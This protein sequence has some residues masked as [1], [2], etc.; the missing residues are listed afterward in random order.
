VGKGAEMTVKDFSTFCPKAIAGIGRLP[1]TVSDRSI[2]IRME[3]K[4]VSQK[5][6]ELRER[7]VQPVAVP[8]RNRITLWVS[9]QGSELWE[10]LP[11]Q[12][13]S[14][15][16]RQ[17]DAVEPLLA[18]A[19]AAGGEWP[20]RARRALVEIL[21]ANAGENES[22]GVTLLRDIKGIFDADGAGKISSAEL[23]ER[24]KQ[25]ET[26]P[27]AEWSKGR[28]LS[29]NALAS[30]LKKYHIYP[31]TIRVGTSTPK[32]YHLEHFED[33]FRRYLE[34][35]I[36]IPPDSGRNNDTRRINT[37]ENLLF[38]AQ[39]RDTMLRPENWVS[40]SKQADCCSV[41]AQKQG[42]VGFGVAPT[43]VPDYLNSV[44][45]AS[46][47]ILTT[48]SMKGNADDAQETVLSTLGDDEHL[49]TR[50]RERGEL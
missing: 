8:L 14:L 48:G 40:S 32:G 38:E 29:V 17:R 16:D 10:A 4:P 20:E 50:D 1:D 15:S 44:G 27:W 46:V 2:P 23:V 12:P 49:G 18:I 42:E 39:Q 28:G 5:L 37:G 41:A 35:E 47:T 33:A 22:I 7:F 34:D 13:A 25:I 19:D 21:T 26:S 45:A 11:E 9:R 6:A 43:A 31:G 30:Q 3:R 36:R 24:L